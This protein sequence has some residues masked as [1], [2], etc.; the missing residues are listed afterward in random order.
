LC[1]VQEGTRKLQIIKRDQVKLNPA[2]SFSPHSL[3]LE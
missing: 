2:D 3:D 1:K